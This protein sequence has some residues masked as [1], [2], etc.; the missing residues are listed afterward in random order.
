M[1]SPGPTSRRANSFVH[2][3]NRS[4]FQPRATS[5]SHPPHRRRRRCSP[6]TSECPGGRKSCVD[7]R[8]YFLPPELL[9]G[10]GQAQVERPAEALDT[11]LCHLRGGECRLN[12]RQRDE[13]L[14]PV[15][16]DDERDGA[17][18]LDA[19][20]LLPLLLPRLPLVLRRLLGSIVL[21]EAFQGHGQGLGRIL[22]RPDVCRVVAAHVAR[23]G[24]GIVNHLGHESIRGPQANLV[25]DSPTIHAGP[26]IVL[27][28]LAAVPLEERL[29]PARQHLLVLLT[30]E[31]D[32]G[33]AARHL[34]ASTALAAIEFRGPSLAILVPVHE[35]SSTGRV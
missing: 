19:L 27:V 31:S 9:R 18:R 13:T 25:P 20:L 29:P 12:H 1:D 23:A 17:L 8:S 5:S 24:L 11:G 16:Q 26:L 30:E 34:L 33:V 3:E 7:G 32:A 14:R 35:V 15:G 22:V 21:L 2:S 6:G 28:G 10:P 4:T